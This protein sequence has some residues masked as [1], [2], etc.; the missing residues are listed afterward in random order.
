LNK[1]LMRSTVERRRERYGA[2]ASR[3]RAGIAANI[4]VHRTRLTRDGERVNAFAERARRAM[5]QLLATRQ[6]R[7]ERGGQLLTAFSYRGVLARGFTLV[8]DAAGRPLRSAAAVTAGAPIEIEFADG[9]LGAHVDDAASAAKP[10]GEA[11]KPRPRR[12]GGSNQGDLF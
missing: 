7:A 5:R 8:R 12:G 3:L 2:I 4:T 9:R 6:A 10:G 11:L 1:Q